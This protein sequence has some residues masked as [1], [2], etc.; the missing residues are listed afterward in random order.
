MQSSDSE[1][2]WLTSIKR[3]EDVLHNLGISGCNFVEQNKAPVI[4]MT[5]KF[6][7]Y[8]KTAQLEATDTVNANPRSAESE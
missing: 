4:E 7:D 2:I 6:L 3:H 8:V 5:R 1:S